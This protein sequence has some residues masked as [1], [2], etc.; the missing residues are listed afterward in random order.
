MSIQNTEFIWEQLLEVARNNTSARRVRRSGQSP[1]TA[2]IPSSLHKLP[3]DTAPPVVLY[4]DPNSWCPF[5][6][7]VWFALE[8]KEIPF[9]TEFI[10]LFNKPKWLPIWFRQPLFQR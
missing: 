4:R 1:S 5:C 9:A 8:E 7:S 10:D 6:E 3:A 2:P